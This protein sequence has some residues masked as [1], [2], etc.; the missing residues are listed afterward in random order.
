MVSLRPDAPLEEILRELTEQA[1]ALWG[2]ERA[3]AISASV[4]AT[5]HRLWA[6]SR[7]LPDRDVEPGFYQ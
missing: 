2:E 6:V 1:K 3:R 5:A 4:E 7:N